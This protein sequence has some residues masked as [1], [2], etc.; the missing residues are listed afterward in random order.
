MIMVK[1][2]SSIKK[3]TPYSVGSPT[4]SSIAEED[5][6]ITAVVREAE[7]RAVIARQR[8]GRMRRRR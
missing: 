7:A 4:P 8:R 5:K 2:A 6:Q 1:P 3:K